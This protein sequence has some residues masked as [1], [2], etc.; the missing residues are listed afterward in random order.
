MASV[1]NDEIQG[2]KLLIDAHRLL[3]TELKETIKLS[4]QLVK[5]MKF[6]TSQDF[7]NL[8]KE[9]NEVTLSTKELLSIE[10]E[11][12]RLKKDLVNLEKAQQQALQAKNKTN[13]QVRKEQERQV[14]ISKRLTQ[15]TQKLTSRYKQES[16]LLNRLRKRFKDLALTEGTATNKT[17]RLRI[18]IQRLDARLKSADASVG[19]FQRNVGNYQSA[20]AGSLGTVGQFATGA[21]AIGAAVL[22]A[23]SAI[24][25]AVDIIKN[26]EQANANLQAVLGVTREEMQ[27]LIEQAKNLGASTAFSA[28]EVTQLNTELAKL[29][30]PIEDIQLMA[31]STL[32]AA[33][34][35]GSDLAAQAAL[36]GSTLKAFGLDASQAQR[37]NDVLAKATSASAL[38]FQKLSSSMATISP[39]AKAFG[40]SLEGTTAL[41][42]ELS[43]AGFDASSAATATRKILL[44]L[45]DSNGKLAKSLKEP[46]KDLP[47]LVRGL[48]QLQ[49]EGTDLGEA[50]ELTDV[51]SVAAFKT[52]LEGT[53]SVL[54]LNDALLDAGGT[55]ERMAKIQLDTLEGQ[56][57]ILN[58][59]W[60][61]LI[62]SM[63]D[64]SGVM[65][66]L[67]KEVI[68]DLSEALSIIGGESKAAKKEFSVLGIVLNSIKISFELMVATVKFLILPFRIM[69][70]LAI[71]LAKR[72][73]FISTSTESMTESLTLFVQILN[74]I[75]E[76]IEIIVDVINEFFL[77]LTDAV[78]GVA[79]VFRGFF[80]GIADGFG[81]VG[82]LAKDFGKILANIFDEEERKK[83]VAKFIKD[84]GKD[85]ISVAASKDIKDGSNAIGTAFLGGITD[86]ISK[87]TFEIKKLLEDPELKETAKEEG[88][89]QENA[90][91]DGVEEVRKERGDKARQDSLDQQ[92]KDF[93][94]LLVSR[95]K[96]AVTIAKEITKEEIE[97]LN[98]SEEFNQERLDNAVRAL[99][100]ETEELLKQANLRATILFEAEGISKTTRKRLLEEAEE[101]RRIILND[102]QKRELELQNK[103]NKARVESEEDTNSDILAARKRLT[104]EIEKFFQGLLELEK[105]RTAERIKNIEDEISAS[106]K[107][108]TR[109][110]QLAEKEKEDVTNNLAFEQ[111][112]RAQLE[113]ERVREIKKQKLQELAL[114]GLKTF[115][116]NLE[117]D[118]NTALPKT[119]SDIGLLLAAIQALG[120]GFYEGTDSVG[121][122][123]SE[124]KFSG[125]KDGYVARLNKGE[126]VFNNKETAEMNRLGA[127]TRT[128]A[129]DM[130]RFGERAKAGNLIAET[131]R[132]VM[133]VEKQP[134]QSNEAFLNEIKGL[135]Q[136]VKNIPENSLSLDQ[137]FRFIKKTRRVGNRTTTD[138]YDVR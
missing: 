129:L 89:K 50:L 38:D 63:E 54:E 15:E 113:A 110:E 35:M 58:S 138:Y 43:N 59:A 83:A 5:G 53:D 16:A 17:K 71:K 81:F 36:T 124:T 42:G 117:N 45:A 133:L 99:K 27:P 106:E 125:G 80:R 44:N 24:R 55:A 47:S 118:P 97:R 62:L 128:K 72:F 102:G 12:A 86:A 84:L 69:I 8:D 94:A 101:E 25:S 130:I 40:F 75:P 115:V 14:K 10:R 73:D 9:I 79:K 28:T 78:V 123:G 2:T 66:T 119:L 131:N 74:N 1:L 87:A 21:G 65:N 41:L 104:S 18:Q 6:E 120:A 103:F 30:F 32:D 68:K 100:K 112:R 108:S 122:T 135:R 116:A 67:A 98:Q 82:T 121:A 23:G 76:I 3:Q 49:A 56:I 29:G 52:F 51:K 26:F 48:K 127:N 126:R 33:T 109:L 88:E 22:I 20:L 85:L 114:L 57:K 34:A 105:Q 31:A 90:R 7:K 46:V 4:N 19:Q 134:Y 92:N 13:I 77:G 61:G 96:Q 37:V 137:F 39:V 95:Q 91:Q 70:D 111:Q 136:D 64:G 60:E 132:A 11:E 93:N 107:R